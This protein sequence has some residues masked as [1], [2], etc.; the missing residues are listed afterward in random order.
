MHGFEAAMH[1]GGAGGE[2]DNA[3]RRGLLARELDTKCCGLARTSANAACD[4]GVW[5]VPRST[6]MR[7]CAE[8]GSCEKS[9]RRTTLQL[10]QGL[11]S[12]PTAARALLR[13]STIRKQIIGRGLAIPRLG[14]VT[15]D[16]IFRARRVTR[17]GHALRPIEEQSSNGCCGVLFKPGV[18]QL[19]DLLADI[20]GVTQPRQLKALQRIARSREKKLPRRLGLVVQ[21]IL[22]RDAHAHADNKRSV[23]SVK[24]QRI[25]TSCGFLWKLFG[26]DCEQ[27]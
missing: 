3:P 18:Q 11:K 2:V 14:F 17:S 1:A 8:S 12:S 26:W 9:V 10:L 7:A 25:S 20:R 22:Q 21:R 13:G 4:A 27:T 5:A 24:I 6:R 19:L 16:P 15:G 23:I